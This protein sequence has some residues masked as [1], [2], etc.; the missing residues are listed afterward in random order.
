MTSHTDAEQ[1]A[2]HA[3]READIA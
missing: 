2:S 3:Y 1:L